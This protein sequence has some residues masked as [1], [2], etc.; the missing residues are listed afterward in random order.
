MEIYGIPPTVCD[1]TRMPS[2]YFDE[3]PTTRALLRLARLEL[4]EVH[5]I[6]PQSYVVEKVHLLGDGALSY[7]ILR[8]ADRIRRIRVMD[9]QN[10]LAG[11]SIALCNGPVLWKLECDVDNPT[12]WR[13]PYTYTDGGSNPAAPFLTMFTAQSHA[14]E[15]R[16]EVA[17]GTT[18][19]ARVCVSYEEVFVPQADR[20]I[21][22]EREVT[23]T[24]YRGTGPDMVLTES[25]ITRSA[26]PVGEVYHGQ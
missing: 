17:D 8:L 7:S 1:L 22:V 18:P 14:L 25:A 21:Y 15:L 16:F 19:E 9:P 6:E 2:N 10:V 26:V 13:C 12:T 5:S 4:D 3:T 11:C 24:H 23:L 20:N